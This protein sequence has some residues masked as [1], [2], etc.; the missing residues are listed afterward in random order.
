MSDE[1][2]WGDRVFP[3]LSARDALA[4]LRELSAVGESD[5]YLYDDYGDPMGQIELEKIVGDA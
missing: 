2:R 4:K 1:V 3:G 5:L